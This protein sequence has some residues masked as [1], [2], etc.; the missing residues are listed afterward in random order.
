[1]TPRKIFWFGISIVAAIFIIS[2]VFPAEGLRV[3]AWT[4]YFPNYRTWLHTGTVTY[5]DIRP[6]ITSVDIL[7]DDTSLIMPTVD[8]TLSIADSNGIIREN[9]AQITIPIDSILAYTYAFE[10]PKG[11][12]TLFYPLFR[13][14]GHLHEHN[15]LIRIL[16]YGDSQIESDRITETIRNYMQKNFGGQGIG[17]IQIVPAS[18]A[19]VTFQQDISPRWTRLSVFD[20]KNEMSVTGRRFGIAGSLVRYTAADTMHRMAHIG[21]LPFYYGYRNARSFTHAR[22]FY[23]KTDMPFT[24]I[25]N[26]TDTQ[27]YVAHD[28]VS[29]AWW[30][31]DKPQTSLYLSLQASVLPDL[32]GIALDG[33]QGVAVD[34]LP[35]RGSSGLDF[36]RMDTAQM[37]M[38]FRMM[39]VEMIIMQFGA[40][41]VPNVVKN[42]D[43]YARGLARQLR[44]LKALKPGLVVLVIGVNDISQHTPNGYIT[45]PNVVKIRNAQRQAA[46]E[47][48][49]VFWD[50]LEAMGGEN[51]M[52]SWAFAQPP[53]AQKDFVHFTPKGAKIVAELFCR[54]W[55]REYY[56]FV[57]Q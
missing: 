45:S 16:H 46:F 42:Y 5:K 21:L 12:D 47:T 41:V 8:D 52:P 27:H 22:L 37:S 38:M 7:D 44:I 17:F 55:S 15:K 49:C 4:F 30:R 39:G 9:Q 35:M 13:T 3:G 57:N 26:K 51:S 53:L 40:N 43:Y 6:I 25:I 32:Y 31:F 50:L 10:F 23:S 36:S 56:Q 48:G 2:V 54:A 18:D 24:V 34:N 33:G 1:M 11:Q 29:S 28:L 19:S 14:I 20:K